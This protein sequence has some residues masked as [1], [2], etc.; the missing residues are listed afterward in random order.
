MIPP[1]GARYYSSYAEAPKLSG[2]AASFSL[3]EHSFEDERIAP[4]GIAAL[5][6]RVGIMRP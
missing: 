5:D 2:R 3:P 6:R 1:P 4:M